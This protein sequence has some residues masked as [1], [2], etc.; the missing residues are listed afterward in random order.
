[1]ARYIDE[2]T[3]P[4]VYDT[5]KSERIGKHLYRTPSGRLFTARPWWNPSGSGSGYFRPL[6]TG[7]AI[8]HLFLMHDKEALEKY[9]DVEFRDG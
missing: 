3:A 8:S 1:M 6:T 2:L 9:F 7:E 5:K 4:E